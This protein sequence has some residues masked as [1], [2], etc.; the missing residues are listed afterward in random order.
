MDTREIVKAKLMAGW[1]G[2][3]LGG[4]MTYDELTDSLLDQITGSMDMS[5][6]ELT[7]EMAIL[8][9]WNPSAITE[10]QYKVWRHLVGE[11]ADEYM[12]G[13]DPTPTQLTIDKVRGI[14]MARGWNE[15]GIEPILED[16]EDMK[17]EDRTHENILRLIEDYEDR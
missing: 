13:N 7:D 6:D 14:L 5:A 17:E 3:V 2:M 10:D 15:D 12:Y 16:V 8:M 1:N 4:L 9:G 11:V